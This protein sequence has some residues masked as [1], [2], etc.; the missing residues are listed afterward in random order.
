MPYIYVLICIMLGVATAKVA[1]RKGYDRILAGV[2]AGISGVFSYGV[3]GL[4]TL[5][6][7]AI[8]S[9]KHN[10]CPNCGERNIFHLSRCRRCDHTI[11]SPSSK[12]P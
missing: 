7:Y 3:A 12:V 4:I 11:Q 10:Y 2:I 6:V 9:P 1:E 8:L 5:A